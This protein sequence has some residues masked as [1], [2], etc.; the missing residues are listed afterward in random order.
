MRSDSQRQ[1]Q[2][3]LR[4]VGDTTCCNIA[5]GETHEFNRLK[6]TVLATT[7]DDAGGRPHSAGRMRL[8]EGGAKEEVTAR[9]GVSINWHGYHVA[10]VAVHGPREPGG[11]F[12]TVRVA[13]I[14]SLPQCIGKT[15]KGP[16]PWPCT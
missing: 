13:P 10:I 1:T 6:I 16:A 8:A 3:P 7:P 12:V 14:G 2:A 9:E 4:E 15:W 11:G 5:P